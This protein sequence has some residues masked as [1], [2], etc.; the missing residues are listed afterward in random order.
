MEKA[1]EEESLSHCISWSVVIC[2]LAVHINNGADVHCPESHT[3][4][5]LQPAI[6][7]PSIMDKAA[8]ET[9]VK[10]NHYPNS[11]LHYCDK[12]QPKKHSCTISCCVYM[13]LI[14]LNKLVRLRQK[15]KHV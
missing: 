4:E 10:A 6:R 7:L 12:C 13:E 2:W 15:T 5:D 11:H 8:I 9:P 14:H 1:A 3:A